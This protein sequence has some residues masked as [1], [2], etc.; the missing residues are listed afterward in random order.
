MSRFAA[1]QPSFVTALLLLAVVAGQAQGQQVTGRV[2]DVQT[3]QPIPAV[4]ISLIRGPDT[5]RAFSDAHG[6]YTLSARE[7]GRFLLMAERIGYARAATAAFELRATESAQMNLR[8]SPEGI[9]LDPVV[10]VGRAGL[11]PGRFAFDR[12]CASGP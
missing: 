3:G 12:R 9:R 6:N 1:A 10:V 8:L 7:P 4:Q 2:L 5:L 11:E